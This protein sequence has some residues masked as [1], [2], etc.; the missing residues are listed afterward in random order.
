[1]NDEQIKQYCISLVGK[2]NFD[3]YDLIEHDLY[4]YCLDGDV[5]IISNF[6]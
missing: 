4:I 3:F 1:M 5:A 2:D 6:Y